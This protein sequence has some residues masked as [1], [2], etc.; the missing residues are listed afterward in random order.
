[1]TLAL[2]R[3]AL[4]FLA[5]LLVMAGA[6]GTPAPA[7]A[8]TTPTVSPDHYIVGGCRIV[9]NNSGWASPVGSADKPCIGVRS[10][11]R[12][13]RGDLDVRL[14]P[15]SSQ[16]AVRLLVTPSSQMVDRGI[17][18]GAGGGRDVITLRL[19]DDKEGKRIDLRT[20]RGRSRVA[21][22]AV[23]IGWTKAGGA[24]ATRTPPGVNALGSHRDR[25]ASGAATVTGG[26]VIRILP[27]GPR[28]HA[29]S[30]HRCIGVKSVALNSSGRIAVTTS[31]E[32]RGA[33]VNVQGDTD[34][35]LTTRGIAA[36]T[37]VSSTHMY[38]SLY[39]S[40]INRRLNLRKPADL[41]R[42]SG[43]TSNLWLTW[44][45]TLNRPGSPNATTRAT[46]SKYGPYQD[47]SA[48]VRTVL[49]RGCTINFA[50][51]RESPRTS[52][53]F[54][55]LCTG[56][57]GIWFNDRGDLVVGG[58][59]P[60]IVGTSTVSSSAL[61]D[62]G[63]RA[64]LSGGVNSS[65]YRFYSMKLGRTLNLTKSADRRVF[66]RSGSSLLI[67]WSGLLA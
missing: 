56:V 36:G 42:A 24:S 58:G 67:G 5:L 37:S 8:A 51:A 45:K 25:S 26:C 22:T 14:T 61:T 47:G 27:T 2:R 13:A 17:V 28:V 29:N 54:V 63:I 35:T 31:S 6:L 43:A 48:P 15:E 32:Q 16:A 60:Q 23:H 39:D 64:G 41:R 40:R 57:S 19:Y 52:G 4:P 18:A 21:T 44:T 7:R 59:F 20:G 9:F 33:V 12:S 49:Q 38:F 3:C 65:T 62:Y 34:E 50:G 1:M 46:P 53:T 10:V 66:E 11:G 30:S 55:R